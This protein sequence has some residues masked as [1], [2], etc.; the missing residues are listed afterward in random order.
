MYF[1]IYYDAMNN[2]ICIAV[3]THKSY[4]MPEDSMYMPLHVGKAI[5]PD[6]DLGLSFTTDNTGDNI[7]NL[8]VS[9]SEL[10]GLYWMWKNCDS[11]YKGLVHYR[12]YFGTT[13]AMTRLMARDRFNRILTHEEFISLLHSPNV[14]DIFLP[15]KRHYY[16]E[17][18]Y[19]HYSHT[20]DGKQF[21]VTREIL[22]EMH[23]E[24]VPFFDQLMQERSA[25][26]FNMFIMHKDKFNEYCAWLFPILKE[27]TNRIPPETY[28]AFGA[29]YPGRVSER[30][31]DVWINTHGYAYTELPVISPEPIDWWSKGTGFLEAKFIG[32]RYSKSF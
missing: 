23:P 24:Y 26:I 5:H 15:K 14:N 12:R 18:I 6:I 17:T 30:L 4:R 19:S 8:N 28:N 16:I 13:H 20:F 22:Q 10:T 3:A 29:R 7:S 32:K 11:T 2:D 1:T 9:Y 31:L 21:D 27:L 25:H